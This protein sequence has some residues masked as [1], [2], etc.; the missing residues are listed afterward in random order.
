MKPSIANR[1]WPS[2]SGIAAQSSPTGTA[3][4]RKAKALSDNADLGLGREAE[5][6]AGGARERVEVGGI[7]LRPPCGARH[8]RAPAPYSGG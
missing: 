3:A 7:H 5:A 2:P 1:R 6:F 4:P 8:S